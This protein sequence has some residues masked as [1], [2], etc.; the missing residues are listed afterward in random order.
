MAGSY[1][2]PQVQVFQTFS[3]APNDV[4]QNLNPF[5]IGPRFLAIAYADKSTRNL[6]THK[7]YD[8]SQL[9]LAW[10]AAMP[11]KTVADKGS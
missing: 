11:K 3:L 6:C 2:L 9:P 8:G 10:S 5:V 1:T 4:T 7:T